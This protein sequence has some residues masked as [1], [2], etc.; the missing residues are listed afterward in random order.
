MTSVFGVTSMSFDKLLTLYLSG[1][2]MIFTVL[3]LVAAIIFFVKGKGRKTLRTGCVI[4]GIYCILYFGTILA[5][6]FLF[7]SNH[8]PPRPTEPDSGEVLWDAKPS[9]M[10][11]GVL[12]GT[13][14]RTGIYS[15]DTTPQNG[16]H[17]DGEITSTVESHEY[18]TQDNQ[19][20]FGT[21]YFYRYGENHTVEIFFDS[22]NKWVIYEPILD[23][24]QTVSSSTEKEAETIS[25][26]SDFLEPISSD[27]FGQDLYDAL[28]KDWAAY[29]AL[30]TEHKM[31]SSHIPGNC[32]KDFDDWAVCEEFIGFSITNPLENN[33]AL[34]K[35]TYVGMPI[36]FMDAPHIRASWYGTRDGHV[37]WVRIQSGYQHEEIRIVVDAKLYGDSAE[38]KPTD[39]GWSAELDRQWYLTKAGSNLPIITEDSAEKYVANTAHLAQGRVLYSIRVIGESAAQNKVQETLE[40][41]LPYWR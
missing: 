7:S 16:G 33:P 11:D 14:G 34:E 23:E 40:Q 21:G 15:T 31:L 30:S 9:V 26:E 37:E 4:V 13:T 39:K 19:S 20:N 3:L 29:D 41:I 22:S 32:R 12:Y 5:L 6:S 36:G 8:E 1:G 27:M 18:P 35:G 2:M 38:G 17:V 25:T 28:Q 10:I 24:Q